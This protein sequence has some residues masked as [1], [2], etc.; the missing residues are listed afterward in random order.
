ML[1]TIYSFNLIIF[2]TPLFTY[3]HSLGTLIY[4]CFPPTYFQHDNESCVHILFAQVISP[5]YVCLT[6]SNQKDC[7]AS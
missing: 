5:G 7:A 6:W 4:F 2:S 1:Y 3:V